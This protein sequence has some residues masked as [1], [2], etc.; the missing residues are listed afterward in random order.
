MRDPSFEVKTEWEVIQDFSKQ[1]FDK[2]TLTPGKNHL[3]ATA[4]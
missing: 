3:V 2:L 1:R 4:G